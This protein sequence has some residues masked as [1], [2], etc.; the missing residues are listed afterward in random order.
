MCR[1][2]Q[3]ELK[4]RCMTSRQPG[5][6]RYA[7]LEREQRWLLSSVPRAASDERV[8][9]DHYWNGTTLRL[10]MIEEGD[11]AVYKLCQKVRVNGSDPRLVKIT[12]IYLSTSEFDHL[13]VTPA[14]II[15]KSRWTLSAGGV[16]YAI[17]EF[18]GRHAGLVLAEVELDEHAPLVAK[19]S[20]AVADVSGD[21]EY[22]G[23]WLAQAPDSE[24]HRLIGRSFEH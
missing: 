14:S 19:P 1:A 24:L 3:Y 2:T 6:G 4:L 18:K 10:R 11:E 13:S 16:T 23:G 7:Q 9:V 22:S 17:D 21:E 8:I 5:E 12:N 15:T 20:F